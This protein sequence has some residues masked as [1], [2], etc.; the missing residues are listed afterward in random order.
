MAWPCFLL[1]PTNRHRRSL[2][3][4]V[5]GAEIKCPLPQGYHTAMVTLDVI[6]GEAPDSGDVWPHD[7]PRWPARCACG[8]EFQAADKWQVFVE[9]LYRRA[10]TGE[11]MALREAP[12]GAMWEAPWL[13]DHW[14]TL[15]GIR[16]PRSSDGASYM[17]SQWRNRCLQEGRIIPPL[18]VKTPGGDWV[19]M[20]SA[21]N[22]SVD[23]DG[24][25]SGWDWSGEPPRIT[26]RPS[27]GMSRYHGW[28]TD[29]V[30]SD[31]MEGRTYP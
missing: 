18:I 24:R 7:D 29:G 16:E 30:L 22:G 9:R 25:R 4:Y 3:R 5:S 28:L 26:A 10:D 13:V 23:A 12:P 8:Y 2:R 11:E 27:I 15:E 14:A 19:I 31:D 17:S 6:E 20:S 1:V 21:S